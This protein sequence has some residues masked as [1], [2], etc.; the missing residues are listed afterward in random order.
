MGNARQLGGIELAHEDP[1]LIFDTDVNKWRL[2][3]CCLKG[4]HTQLYEADR[5]DGPFTR[6]AG[7]TEHNSTGVLIQKIGDK[8][9]AFSG[10]GAG[11]MLIYSYPE[12]K[13]LGQMKIDLPAHWPKGPGRGWPNVFPLPPGFPSRYMALMMDRPNFPGVTGPN[14]SYGALYL[15]TA[16]TEDISNSPYEYPNDRAIT[17]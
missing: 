5:W 17:R 7:P 15:F 3:T 4:F 8:R 13:F 2:L 14:W 16:F 9:Y 10:N 11:P 12:L 1:C 6:I